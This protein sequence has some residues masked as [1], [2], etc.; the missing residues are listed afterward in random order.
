MTP[1]GLPGD[2]GV[3]A[4]AFDAITLV[5]KA[6]ETKKRIHDP[7]PN[8]GHR[9]T[10]G[11]FPL[12]YRHAGASLSPSS[13]SFTMSLTLKG[14]RSNGQSL[15]RPCTL[16]FIRADCTSFASCWTHPNWMSACCG[17]LDHQTALPTPSALRF[18]PEGPF[19]MATCFKIC[20]TDTRWKVDY[21]RIEHPHSS[22]TPSGLC[23]GGPGP[24]GPV[25]T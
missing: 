4:R 17:D 6:S 13:I 10:D 21:P 3:T 16:Q 1:A 5:A 24:K 15:P 18:W 19:G 8:T 2:S 11:K 14:C 25:R 9:I 20:G 23:T 22:L 7:L 12:A